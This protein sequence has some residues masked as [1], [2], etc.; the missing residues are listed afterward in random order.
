MGEIIKKLP[1]WLILAAAVYIAVLA[2]YAVFNNQTVEFWPPTIHAKDEASGPAAGKQP[3]VPWVSLGSAM[4]SF[5]VTEC[6]QRLPAA[7]GR[8]QATGIHSA[9]WGGEDGL[10]WF[11]ELGGN[12]VWLACSRGASPIVVGA[13]GATPEATK[14]AVD[15]LLGQLAAR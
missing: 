7:L 4:A 9:T 5:P 3:S 6:S 11:G 1:N 8:A 10:L 15:A 2:S 14:G 13:A 12:T